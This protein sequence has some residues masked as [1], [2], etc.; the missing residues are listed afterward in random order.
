M[1]QSQS[2]QLSKPRILGFESHHY[3]S[4]RIFR[5]QTTTM[6]QLSCYQNRN[7]HLRNFHCNLQSMLGV[8]KQMGLNRLKLLIKLSLKYLLMSLLMKLVVGKFFQ[9]GYQWLVRIL[10][11]V[12][13]LCLVV[14]IFLKDFL[15]LVGKY[16]QVVKPY[17]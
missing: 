8:Y 7:Q 11:Q 10:L 1:S 9:L 5:Q 2:L 17:Y 12:D 14:I 3:I 4:R 6:C 16:V 13:L 15:C